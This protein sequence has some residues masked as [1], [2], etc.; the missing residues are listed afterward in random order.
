[1]DWRTCGSSKEPS[2]SLCYYCSQE[3]SRRWTST[4]CPSTLKTRF[5]ETAQNPCRWIV[6]C[7]PKQK[8]T[9]RKTHIRL[10]IE[11]IHQQPGDHYLRR[12]IL[13]IVN[14]S[15]A[16]YHSPTTPSH[17]RCVSFTLFA[18]ALEDLRTTAYF[19][20]AS[21]VDTLSYTTSKTYLV[22]GHRK[23]SNSALYYLVPLHRSDPP[24]SS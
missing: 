8:E 11:D 15:F 2:P 24:L 18:I 13:S 17:T 7:S 4:W 20:S 9:S 6:T 23:L 14:P 22:L 1:V 19:R 5:L 16:T 12:A 21:Y 10:S 3:I